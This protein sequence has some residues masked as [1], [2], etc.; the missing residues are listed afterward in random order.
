MNNDSMEEEVEL[1]YLVHCR[2][3]REVI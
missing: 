2:Y 3:L 1:E